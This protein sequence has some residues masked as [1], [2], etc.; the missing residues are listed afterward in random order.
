MLHILKYIIFLCGY[1]LVSIVT[2]I[3]MI[4]EKLDYIHYQKFG[5]IRFLNVFESLFRKS[6]M[7][8]QGRIYL[9]KNT[10]KIVIRNYSEYKILK[11]FTVL[12]N[13]LYIYIYI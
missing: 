8:N 10:V 3:K 11:N 7:L 13:C 2:V 1:K 12:N 9:I 5:L 6:L 4:H